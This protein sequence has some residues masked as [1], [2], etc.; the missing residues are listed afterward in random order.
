MWSAALGQPMPLSRKYID[1]IFRTFAQSK[2]HF[3]FEDYKRTT[4]K[5]PEILLWLTKPEEAMNKKL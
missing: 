5:D 4:T 3:D 1:Q 2:N